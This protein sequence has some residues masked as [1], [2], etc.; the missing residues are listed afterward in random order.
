MI[1]SIEIWKTL[2]EHEKPFEQKRADHLQI[3]DQLYTDDI[4]QVENGHET[5]HGKANLRAM[6]S[7][8]L[9][10]VNWVK[11]KVK[12]LVFDEAK[13]MLWAELRVDFETKEGVRK[14]LLESVF[15]QWENGKIKV[16]KFYYGPIKTTEE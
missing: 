5:I 8:N 15:Q 13:S 16:Q 12:N 4:V 9:D 11:T 2:L 10:K 1:Q 3:V 14:V 7:D 6:E